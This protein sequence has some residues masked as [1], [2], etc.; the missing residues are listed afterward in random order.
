M[1]S[2]LS[3]PGLLAIEVP[4]WNRAVVGWRSMA[5]NRRMPRDKATA[6]LSA[7]LERICA[8]GAH[9][10]CVT[11]VY[12]FGSYARGALTVGDV[13]VDIEYD[14]RLHPE[15]ERELLD[16]LVIG[17]DWNTP[18]RKALRPPSALQVLFSK[19]D[20]IAEPV[21]V[22]ERGD[23]LDQVLARVDAIAPDPGAGRAERDAVHPAIEPVADDLARPTR[24]LLTEL[25]TADLLAVELVDLADADEDELADRR[26]L[27]IVRLRWH[28]PS[29][30]LAR[31]A[32]AAGGYLHVAGVDL[33]MVAL[34]PLSVLD[35]EGSGWAVDCRET[36]LRRLVVYLGHHGIR[37]A[38]FVLHPER[39]RPL[40]ALRLTLPD[41]VALPHT[42]IEGW[43]SQRG[44]QIH[45]IG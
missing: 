17:R 28:S 12:V 24:I 19:I 10:D 36:H 7:L 8:G 37:D 15:V 22:Y 33:G 20:V 14:A 4:T 11:G 38:L 26:F 1:I 16:N 25:L 18:F 9:A 30:P 43:L 3:R 27:T 21:L 29:S 45:R 39:K 23:R 2:E 32:R 44:P 40:R 41:P 42:D 35:Q 13:D 34:M 31:A 5:G 6:A